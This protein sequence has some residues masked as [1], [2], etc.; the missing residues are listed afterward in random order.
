MKRA[1]TTVALLKKA[2]DLCVDVPGIKAEMTRL[3]IEHLKIIYLKN[4]MQEAALQL[5]WR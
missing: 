5:V 4:N 3:C 2:S 1:S